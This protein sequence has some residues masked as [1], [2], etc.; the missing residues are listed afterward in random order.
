MVLILT[1]GAFLIATGV[2][3]TGYRM[4][5]A[6][7]PVEQR[8]RA[9][10]PDG[11]IRPAAAPRREGL[12]PIGRVLTVIGRIGMGGNEGVLRQRLSTAGLQSTNAFYLFLGARTLLSFG[13]AL[14]Y[15]IP[16]VSAGEPLGKSLLIAAGL[17]FIGHLLCTY[18]LLVQARRRIRLIRHAL[19]DSLDLMVVCLEAGLGLTATIA[20]V[21]E[22]RSSMSD[23]L[24]IEFARVARELQEGRP[25]DEAL[26]GLADRNGVDDLKSLV[27]LIVQT[28]KL[29]ASMAKTLRAHAD[30]L[31][32]KR[33][34]RAEEAARKLP[35]K[36]LFPLAFFILPSLFTVAIGPAVLRIMDLVELM[37]HN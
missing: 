8:L 18:W 34:Q 10:V 16:K 14:L 3:L 4:L 25:R 6:E 26:R 5:T 33:R 21:G 7:S 24:G 36:I 11:G 23:P 15:L 19:P 1:F 32:T 30:V 29:G 27:G 9:V 22:E 37:G 17:W 2:V 35:I 13:P 20:R 12:G 31:R 28:D